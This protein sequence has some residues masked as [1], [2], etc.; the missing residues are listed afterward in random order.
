MRQVLSIY[1]NKPG[2]GC[3]RT[4]E[5]ENKEFACLIARRWRYLYTFILQ[6]IAQRS[7]LDINSFTCSIYLGK[8]RQTIDQGTCLM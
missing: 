3:I 1:M 2:W 6:Q 5:T 4:R 8:D 7:L